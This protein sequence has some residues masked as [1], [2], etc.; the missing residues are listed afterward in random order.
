V[1]SYWYLISYGREGIN[2]KHLQEVK[3]NVYSVDAVDKSTVSR[4]AYDWQV[5]KNTKQSL[6]LARCSGWTA[7][8]VTRA[9][10]QH[11]IELI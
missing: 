9:L 1:G 11:A 3:Q 8:A 7:R 4:W 10:L 2:K 6:V 5:L